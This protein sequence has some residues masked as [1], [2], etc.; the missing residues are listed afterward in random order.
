MPRNVM[1]ELL[2]W[3]YIL[4]LFCREKEWYEWTSFFH[5]F[6]LEFDL[7]GSIT[8]ALSLSFFQLPW[9]H[10]DGDGS[11]MC[12]QFVLIALWTLISPSLLLVSLT[13]YLS[14]EAKNCSTHV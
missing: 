9:G 14:A 8:Q 6:I 7:I 11:L 13:D 5:I 12:P 4:F 1:S 10:V 3:L 2:L